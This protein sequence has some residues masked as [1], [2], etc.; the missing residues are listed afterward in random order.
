M[1]AGEDPEKV[2]AEMGDLLETEDPFLMPGK[3]GPASATG[4]GAPLKDETLYDL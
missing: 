1:E 2:E 4:R 3:K